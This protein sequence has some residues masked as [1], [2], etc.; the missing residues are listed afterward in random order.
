MQTSDPNDIK[1]NI[2]MLVDDSSI[3]NYVNK[4]V[5]LRYEFATE[6]V[7]YTNS[8]KALRDILKFRNGDQT[9]MPDVIFLD[10]N[11]PEIDG[12]EFMQSFHLLPDELKE[13]MKVVI[14]TSSINP[15]DAEICGKH[16]SVLTFLH[17]PLVKGNLDAIN[18]L[19]NNG[20]GT[21]KVA[22]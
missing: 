20:Q 22:M 14:L 3:D 4:K 13:K 10:L 2:V 9:G 21:L 5:L 11:M 7:T 6:V 18:L 17:K 15:K 1:H 16:P 12:Y 19:M 8:R